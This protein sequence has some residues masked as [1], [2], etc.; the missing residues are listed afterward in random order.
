MSDLEVY[1]HHIFNDGFSGDEE[2]RLICRMYADPPS[3]DGEGGWS[4]PEAMIDINLENLGAPFV[5]RTWSGNYFDPQP[6]AAEVEQ[7]EA[8]VRRQVGRLLERLQVAAEKVLHRTGSI[9]YDFVVDRTS[10]LRFSAM[11]IFYAVQTGKPVPP[12]ALSNLISEAQ[13]IRQTITKALA[14]YS[15]EKYSSLRTAMEQLRDALPAEVSA[16]SLAE[17]IGSFED[18]YR[19]FSQHVE[20]F[21]LD[22][23][24]SGTPE[25]DEGENEA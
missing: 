8:E 23:W 11:R 10:Q 14:E 12:D 24:A 4:G 7:V 15:G 13:Y 9:Q 21:W 1:F 25:P 5:W 6:P 3:L 17:F 18:Q 16:D 20:S 19:E 22:V 2:R